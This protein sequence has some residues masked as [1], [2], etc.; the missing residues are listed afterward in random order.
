M[1]RS[2]VPNEEPYGVRVRRSGR[3]GTNNETNNETNG[4]VPTLEW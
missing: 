2:A 4:T 3:T 1:D